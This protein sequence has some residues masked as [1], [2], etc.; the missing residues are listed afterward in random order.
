MLKKILYALLASLLIIQFIRPDKNETAG[1]FNNNIEKIYPMNAMVKTALHRACY[2]CH[3]NNT[4]YPWY[5]EIQP[6]R[7]WLQHHVDEGKEHLN[8]HEMAAYSPDKLDHKFEEMQEAVNE[9]WMPLTSYKFVHKE[10]VLTNEEKAAINEWITQSRKGNQLA[11]SSQS[12]ENEH[13]HD[14][15]ESV[16]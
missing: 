8:F 7:W 9:E 4:K 2:D 14:H 15:H 5:A 1:P 3:S 13:V 6:V 10:A 11:Q 12:K 16:H